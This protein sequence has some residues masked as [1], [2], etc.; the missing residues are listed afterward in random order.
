MQYLLC[1]LLAEWVTLPS[2]ATVPVCHM[3]RPVQTTIMASTFEG[4]VV[5]AADTRTSTGNY[6]ANRTSPKLTQLADNAFMCRSGVASDTQAIAGYVQYYI[7][8]HEI[9]LNDQTP[10][11]VTANLVREISYKNKSQLGAGMIVAG[12]DKQQ[13]ASVFAI[14]MG[15]TCLKVRF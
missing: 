11:A 13:G 4:G 1:V 12:W 9:E 8:Q 5:L 7:A 14:P 10:V 3:L 15:G 6:V 2:D